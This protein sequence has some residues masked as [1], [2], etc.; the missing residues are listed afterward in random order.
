MHIYQP[1]I[2]GQLTLEI[3]FL[4]QTVTHPHQLEGGGERLQPGS[5]V[6]IAIADARFGINIG[7]AATSSTRNFFFMYTVF[8]IKVMKTNSRKI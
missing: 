7:I 5:S 3:E 6:S 2:G 8:L 4:A 1:P